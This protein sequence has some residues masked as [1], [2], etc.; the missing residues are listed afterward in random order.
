MTAGSSPAAGVVGLWCSGLTCHS[1]E[2]KIEGSNPSSPVCRY[3]N[4]KRTGRDPVDE[5]S[6]PFRHLC[7]LF[8]ER[9]RAAAGGRGVDV[10]WVHG[11]MREIPF[12]AEFDAVLNLFTAF[13]YLETDEEDQK[14]L[15]GVQKAL[16]PGGRFLMEIIHRDS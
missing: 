13:G 16:K 15:A 9:A 2:V 10:R 6:T 3:A 14:V 1:V 11:D 8:L 7:E 4:G 12:A 5:G